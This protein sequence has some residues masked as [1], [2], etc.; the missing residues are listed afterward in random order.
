MLDAACDEIAK[1]FL[2][3]RQPFVLTEKECSLTSRADHSEAEKSTFDIL[4][5]SLCR[6]ARPGIARLIIEDGKAVVYHCGD[7]AREYHGNAL[8][9]IEFEM[10]DGPAIEQLLTT[11]EPHWI[12]VNDLYHDTIEDKIAIVQSLYDEGILAVKHAEA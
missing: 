8:S 9:P 3:D 10:D 1:R 5:N 6:L 7:N 4:P 12:F 11:A 2:S